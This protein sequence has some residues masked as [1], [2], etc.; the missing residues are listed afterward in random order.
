VR[1]TAGNLARPTSTSHHGLLAL[2]AELAEEAA[3]VGP[4]P[5]FEQASL[6]VEPKNVEQVPN[7][8]LPVRRERTDRRL[9]ELPDKRSF[10]PRLTRDVVPLDH[11]DAATYRSIVKG[12]ADRREVAGESFVIRLEPVRL[13]KRN[14]AVAK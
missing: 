12:G 9:C 6:V 2:R 10:H 3:V 4:H 14:S 8:P 11:H 13:W 7:D 5:F 1:G